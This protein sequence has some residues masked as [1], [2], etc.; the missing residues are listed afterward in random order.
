MP[1]YNIKG[2]SVL[3]VHIPKTG[4]TSLE[5]WLHQNGAQALFCPK[6]PDWLPCPPQHLHAEILAKIIPSDYV[7]YAFAVTR[8]PTGRFLSEFFYQMSNKKYRPGWFSKRKLILS[9]NPARLGRFFA[10][11]SMTVLAEYQRDSFARDNHIRPQS[12]YLDYDGLHVFRFE[13]GLPNIFSQLSLALN[14]KAPMT[15]PNEKVSKR[16]SF[17]V[18]HETLDRI[19]AFYA[20]DFQRLNYT[21][22]PR[23]L[24]V[25][26]HSDSCSGGQQSIQ[27]SSS[28]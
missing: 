11:W 17:I 14:L 26:E 4:G 7:D 21:R 12:Q 9:T 2:K 25:N 15:L 23:P 13:D 22:C 5:C 27:R 1:L 24:A 20:E 16:A 3:F 18:P 28:P 10:T 19:E 8:Q 6:K